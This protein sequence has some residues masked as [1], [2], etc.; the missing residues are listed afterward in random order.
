MRINR[1]IVVFSG[2]LFCILAA[3][4]YPQ[5]IPLFFPYFDLVL[6]FVAFFVLSGLAL[7]VFPSDKI[8]AGIVLLLLLGGF[9]EL[10]QKL[11]L[12]ERFFSWTDLLAN[13]LG[14]FMACILFSAFKLKRK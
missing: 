12:T 1:G 7:F 4:L 14:I 10:C 13:S 6:H 5:P 8:L 9:I 11:I 2:V 3:G